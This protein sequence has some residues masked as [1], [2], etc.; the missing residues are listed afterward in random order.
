M[1]GYSQGAVIID[2]DA[3]AQYLSTMGEKVSDDYADRYG[4]ER[5]HFVSE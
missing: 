1:F 3:I 5:I 2:V 4:Q